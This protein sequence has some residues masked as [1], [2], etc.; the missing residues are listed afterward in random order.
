MSIDIPLFGSL[1]VPSSGLFII[2]RYALAIL[3]HD[4]EI[5]LCCAISLFSGFPEPRGGL[6]IIL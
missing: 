4:A 1:S 6:L 5:I 2:L 3:I